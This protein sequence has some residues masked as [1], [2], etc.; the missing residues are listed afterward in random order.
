MRTFCLTRLMNCRMNEMTKWK[1]RMLMLV[2]V[3]VICVGAYSIKLY[4]SIHAAMKD[5]HK[6]LVKSEAIVAPI[7]K[8][9]NTE[10]TQPFSVLLLGVDE[11]KGDVGRSDTMIVVTVNP[12]QQSLKMLSIPRDTRAQIVGNNTVEKINHAYA[13]GGIPMTIASVEKL[14]NL[15]IDYYVKV[16][17]EGFLQIIDVLEGITVHNDVALTA[18]N[19]VFP[20]GQ[21]TLNAEQALVFSRIRYEDPRGDFGRQVRQRQIIEAILN[22]ANSVSLLWKI[23]PIVEQLKDEIGRAHV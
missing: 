2:I 9:N 21:I 11:R 3:L 13:R 19:H 17:M 22:K 7:K 18:G 4:L 1:K 8:Q 15:P 23:E 6:P 5:I 16:N 20:V 12:K 14:L 10:V